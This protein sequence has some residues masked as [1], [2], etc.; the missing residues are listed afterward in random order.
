MH[1]DISSLVVAP[2]LW[3]VL[4][5]AAVVSVRVGLDELVPRGRIVQRTRPG[6]AGRR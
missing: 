5:A 4:I 3:R 6:A 2:V 1:I